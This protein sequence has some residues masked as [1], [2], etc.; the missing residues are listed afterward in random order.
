MQ[1]LNSLDSL[2]LQAEMPGL[3]MLVSSIGIY[4][5]ASAPDEQV[6]FKDIMQMFEAGIPETSLFR[7]RL[8]DVPLGLDQPYWIEDPD[9]DVEFHVRHIALPH[10]GDWRQLYIQLARLQSRPLDKTRPLWEAYVIEGLNNLDGIPPGSFCIMLKVHHAAMGGMGAMELLTSM[11][12]LSPSRPSR[13]PRS[14]AVLVEHR[15]GTVSLLRNALFN[16]LRRSLKSPRRLLDTVG[17]RVRVRQGVREGR[18]RPSGNRIRTRFNTRASSYRTIGQQ[19]MPLEAV[20][21][22]AN[23]AGVTIQ[24][25]ML[26]VVGGALRK[27]LD[28]KNEL[29]ATSLVAGTPVRERNGAAGR[30]QERNLGFMNILLHTEIAD[31]RQ[32]LQ[33][34][35]A[36]AEQARAQVDTAGINT[37]DLLANAMPPMATSVL[38]HTVLSGSRLME[39]TQNTIVQFIPGVKVP[40]YLCGA[41][42]I[43]AFVLGPITHGLGLYHAVTSLYDHIT[44]A[45]TACRQM[46]PDPAFYC[47][48]L[49]DS[50]A[51]LLGPNGYPLGEPGPPLLPPPASKRRGRP[52]AG[53]AAHPEN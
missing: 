52:G 24:D 53:A 44:I 17:A 19:R 36:D 43:D 12:E 11:H 42:L 4:D 9:F 27:Y 35:K 10:P 25:V 50:F 33:A 13:R 16:Q 49:Q 22:I 48:C 5:P 2:F 20:E 6:R 39:P 34:I 3:P 32:R 18:L 23:N 21:H 41:K 26:C 14:S 31:P 30:K 37:I 47:K 45:V 51:E 28:A 40:V 15:P 1:Q 46:L 7:R 38:L 8:V 29:P